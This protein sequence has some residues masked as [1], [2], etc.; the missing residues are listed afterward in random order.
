MQTR[1]KQR[2]QRYYS[3]YGNNNNTINGMVGGLAWIDK[4]NTKTI[5]L[6]LK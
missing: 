6:F 3:N 5:S 4:Q 2:R 1:T